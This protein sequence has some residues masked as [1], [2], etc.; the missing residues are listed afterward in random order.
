V[1]YFMLVEELVVVDRV[2]IP[3]VQVVVEMVV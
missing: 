2:Y 1:L 3:E